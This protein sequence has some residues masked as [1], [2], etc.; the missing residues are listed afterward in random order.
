MV[1]R[2]VGRRGVGRQRALSGGGR[3]T[4]R[5]FYFFLEPPLNWHNKISIEEPFMNG[6]ALEQRYYRPKQKLLSG[7]TRISFRP[8]DHLT[9]NKFD[10]ACCNI[11]SSF[12]L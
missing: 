2:S 5:S 12:T 3:R 7:K 9:Q 6:L 4:D 8:L 11:Y 1:E 10:L